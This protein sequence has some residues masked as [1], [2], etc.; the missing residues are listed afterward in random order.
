[1][2]ASAITAA[3]TK[4]QRHNEGRRGVEKQGF[5]PVFVNKDTV[6][7]PIAFKENGKK[8]RGNWRHGTVNVKRRQKLVEP[9]MF[10]PNQ[11]CPCMFFRQRV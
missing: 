6:M 10:Q 11:N 8:G 9:N 5:Q 3:K 4:T 7:D 1:M 2:S